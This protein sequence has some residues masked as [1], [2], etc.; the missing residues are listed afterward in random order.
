LKEIALVVRDAQTPT[1][2]FAQLA[3]TFDD[4]RQLTAA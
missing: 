4:G 1:T 3:Q 2:T